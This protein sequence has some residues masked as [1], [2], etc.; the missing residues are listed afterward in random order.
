MRSKAVNEQRTPF[1]RRVSNQFVAA[2]ENV[3]S[4]DVEHRYDE[5]Y[6]T[7]EF[8]R[9]EIS[10]YDD[11]LVLTSDAYHIVD[12]ETGAVAPEASGRCRVLPQSGESVRS[13]STPAGS[14]ADG[15]GFTCVYRY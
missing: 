13:R 6:I 8:D 3:S 9:G 12:S 7:A 1:S 15:P 2:D 4:I 11:H 10:G 5:L 14:H